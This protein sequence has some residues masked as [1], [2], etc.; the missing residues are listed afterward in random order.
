[1]VD[2]VIT[3]RV[4]NLAGDLIAE[5]DPRQMTDAI[6]CIR[7]HLS[8]DH[9]ADRS[10]LEICPCGKGV[11]VRSFRVAVNGVSNAVLAL[12]YEALYTMKLLDDSTFVLR[13]SKGGI[14][15]SLRV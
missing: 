3:C 1:M 11:L 7:K 6:R 13:L 15:D 2:S 4:Y 8:D 9:V 10:E 5:F 12:E 14:N